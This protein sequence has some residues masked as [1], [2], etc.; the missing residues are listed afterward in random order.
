MQSPDYLA[1]MAN[2]V[3][4]NP[5]ITVR[6]IAREL[7][8][9]DNKSVYYWLDKYKFHGLRDFK[10][11]VLSGRQPRDEGLTVEVGGKQCYAARVALFS[12]NPKEKTPI[13]EWCFL[14]DEPNPQGLFA[15]QVG[16]ERFGPWLIPHD[17]LIIAAGHG[18][19]VDGWVLLTGEGQFHLGFSLPGGGIID[20]RTARG[21]PAEF[22]PVGRIVRQERV[23]RSASR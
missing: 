11:A 3:R 13:G 22:H 23:F 15:V 12:W 21:V 2:L 6:E 1:Q 17:I 4:A 10:R 5:S 19:P 18:A 7:Q 14:H 8:F 9:A 20:P 16:D